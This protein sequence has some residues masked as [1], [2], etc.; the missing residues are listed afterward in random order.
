MC[1]DLYSLTLCML[2]LPL[3]LHLHCFGSRLPCPDSSYFGLYHMEGLP[4]LLLPFWY[5]FLTKDAP[6]HLIISL[7]S[8]TLHVLPMTFVLLTCFTFCIPHMIQPPWLMPFIAFRHLDPETGVMLHLGLIFVSRVYLFCVSIS[9]LLP[10]VL[11]ARLFLFYWTY[12]GLSRYL[13]T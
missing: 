8:C 4:P 11:L 10:C 2:P 6:H 12:L 9:S 1:R 5:A 3:C 7:P 13:D